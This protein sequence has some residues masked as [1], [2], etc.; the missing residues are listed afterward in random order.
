MLIKLTL[1]CNTTIHKYGESAQM[2]RRE[3]EA[4][5]R[6]I[7]DS[8]E[9]KFIGQLHFPGREY[10]GQFFLEAVD[11]NQIKSPLKSTSKEDSDSYDSDLDSNDFELVAKKLAKKMAMKNK[12][13]KKSSSVN[14][15]NDHSAIDKKE[16]KNVSH[17][18]KK[19]GRSDPTKCVKDENRDS[20]KSKSKEVR[21]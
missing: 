9:C 19:A 6:Q 11:A 7:E 3:D 1:I 10:F 20:E 2:K 21:E 12:T 16:I 8:K 17:D 4:Q 5:M 14:L 18:D 15:K 13:I